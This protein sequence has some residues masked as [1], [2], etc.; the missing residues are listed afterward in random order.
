MAAI[1]SAT[2]VLALVM[3]LGCAANPQQKAVRHLEAGRKFAAA[4]DFARAAIEYRNAVRLQPANADALYQLGVA[5]LESGNIGEAAACFRRTIA[6]DSGHL[7][8]RIKLASLELSS[9]NKAAIEDAEQNAA[10]VV[11]HDASNA[12]GALL[13]AA[14]QLRLGKAEE[15]LK[16]L[17]QA[18][19]RFPQHLNAAIVLAN[20]R[21]RG[22]DVA[23]AEAVLAQAVNKS[24]KPLDA[25]VTLG[26]FH[27]AISKLEDARRDFEKALAIAPR[28]IRARNGLA[29]VLFETGDRDGALGILRQIFDADRTDRGA[30]TRLVSA[31]LLTGRA[32][33]AR[34]LLGAA[35]EANPKDTEALEFRAR[36]L[37]MEGKP[38]EAQQDISALL[39][40]ESKLPA[41]H[42]LQAKVHQARG[43]G[44]SYHAALNEALTL[45]PE[46]LPARLELSQYLRA[47]GGA[48]TA[49]ELLDKM[50]ARQKELVE[51]RIE[52][53][54][55]LIALGDTAAARQVTDELKLSR[56]P[57]FLLQA[58]ALKVRNEP[59]AA[60]ALV[61]E[62]LAANSVASPG[63][64]RGLHL[65]AA[66]YLREGKPAAARTAIREYAA[67]QPGSAAIQ[68]AAAS[69][70]MALED[71]EG[72]RVALEAAKRAGADNPGMPLLSGIL[73]HAEGQRGEAAAQFR[74]AVDRDANNLAALNNLAWLLGEE[75]R[76][77]EAL[78][79]AQRAKELAPKSAAVDDT[80]GWIY[81]RMGVYHSAL[82]HLEDAVAREGTPVRNYHLAMA[83]YKTG[84]AGRA[85][86]SLLAAL[87]QNP[88]LPE[89]KAAAAMLAAR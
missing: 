21:L 47:T 4:G 30:R 65:L 48:K 53:N 35:L 54:W 85:R 59:G 19:S 49:L 29:L 46:L 40:L 74:R 50:P 78:G 86:Q 26:Y 18:V 87:R 58:A 84:D 72:A 5:G 75:G 15:G 77:Q 61:E 24:P 62:S 14:A 7:Q 81:F 3:F 68:Y 16:G 55:V 79:F 52:R 80:I 11:A 8:A 12:D 22:K 69:R 83:Y 43:A 63:A 56:H 57:E 31:C 33:E 70:L 17:E 23:G 89:A 38:D 25:L 10:Q 66:T 88:N 82:R 34:Q 67:S 9:A 37:L 36:V 2:P 44:R 42:Y 20:Q 71:R 64:T 28:D 32:A 13:L 27:G 1:R 41:G 76:Y 45:N 51:T 73:A 6:L 60:R 39:T